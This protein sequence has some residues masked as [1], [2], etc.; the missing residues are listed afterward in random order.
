MQYPSDWGMEGGSNPSTVASFYPQRDYRSD[1][2]VGIRN[3][4]TNY[5]PDQYLNSLMRGDAA[6]YKDFPDI[7]LT[8]NTT[9]TIVLAISSIL[10]LI[11]KPWVLVQ[12][13]PQQQ[14][15]LLKNP[16][17]DL[18]NHPDGEGG[19]AWCRDSLA[20]KSHVF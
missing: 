9:N 20:V 2:I 19:L 10:L 4:T 8:Q 3:L 11:T 1:V 14:L 16:V 15:T 7:R 17:D 5:T 6:D 18:L 13:T 12:H